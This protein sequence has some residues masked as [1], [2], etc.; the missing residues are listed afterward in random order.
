M[1]LRKSDDLFWR[2]IGKEGLE[3]IKQSNKEKHNAMFEVVKDFL[4]N[5]TE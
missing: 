3:E 4:V 1:K 2:K 5:I